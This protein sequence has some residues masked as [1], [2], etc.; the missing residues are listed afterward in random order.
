MQA[1]LKKSITTVIIAA[2]MAAVTMFSGPLHTLA[3]AEDLANTY[4]SDIVMITEEEKESRASEL[5]GY[6]IIDEPIHDNKSDAGIKTYIAYKTTKNPEEAITD[7]RVMNMNGNY[8]FEEY[9]SYVSDLR[10]KA[11]SSAAKLWNSVLEFR[12]LYNNTNTRTENVKYAYDLLNILYDEDILDSNGNPMKIG[13][14][15]AGK[16][17]LTDSS[18]ERYTNLFLESNMDALQMIY[19]ALANACSKTGGQTFL[20]RLNDDPWGYIDAYCDNSSL[21]SFVSD[22]LNITDKAREQ[23]TYYNSSAQYES[24]SSEAERNAFMENL[25][26]RDE[27]NNTNY[28]SVW[29]NGYILKRELSN[30]FYPVTDDSGLETDTLYEL[31]MADEEY[32]KNDELMTTYLRPVVGAMSEGMRP[33]LTMGLASIVSICATS[34][35]DYYDTFDEL[36]NDDEYKDVFKN[37]ISVFSGVDREIYQEHAVAMTGSAI[38]A[39]ANGE[40]SWQDDPNA[41]SE[42]LHKLATQFAIVTGVFG[43][44][45]LFIIGVAVANAANIVEFAT[46]MAV[47][48]ASAFGAGFSVNVATGFGFMFMGW[49]IIISIAAL[50]AT[51]VLFVLSKKYEVPDY[52]EYSEIPGMLCDYHKETREDVNH[53][54]T[55]SEKYVYYKGVADPFGVRTSAHFGEDGDEPQQLPKNR[56]NVMDVYDWGLRSTRQWVALYTTKDRYAGYPILADSLTVC[57]TQNGGLYAT[58][59]GKEKSQQYDFSEIYNHSAEVTKKGNKKTEAIYINYLVD[60]DAV[61]PENKEQDVMRTLIGSAVSNGASWGMG[62]IGLGLGCLGGILIGKHSKKKLTA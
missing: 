58:A 55:T 25:A 14:L 33:L 21:D 20:S 35:G 41:K 13:D 51:I 56:K 57:S 42:K 31:I 11:K 8:S 23:I 61:Y 53:V 47:I 34:N 24:F 22:F 36:K 32:Y 40:T 62:V 9:D 50:I 39:N 10:T 52:T 6:I 3:A 45:S 49:A 44:V 7:I 1:V 26:E 2:L 48:L 15:F 37:G 29:L 16:D 54:T 28:L 19:T 27:K 18:D 46:N 4:I 5:G 60:E 12:T 38:N 43:F 17:V 59:F 30:V